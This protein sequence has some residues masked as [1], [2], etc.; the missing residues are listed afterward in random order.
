MH[1]IF[2][3]NPCSV[4]LQQDF[5]P[6]QVCRKAVYTSGL[7]LLKAV[8][9]LQNHKDPSFWAALH[10]FT[11]YSLGRHAHSLASVR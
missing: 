8:L 6:K 5:G 3:R 1:V 9:Y 4:R 2:G 11:M 10:Y 7:A